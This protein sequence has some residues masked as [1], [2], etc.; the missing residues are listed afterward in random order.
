LHLIGAARCERA[1]VVPIHIQETT[2]HCRSPGVCKL[3]VSLHPC[4]SFSV[5]IDAFDYDCVQFIDWNK[6]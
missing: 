1:T 6:V 2:V 3:R 4:K 5:F